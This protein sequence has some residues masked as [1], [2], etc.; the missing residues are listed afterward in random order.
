MKSGFKHTIHWIKCQSKISTKILNRYL[1]YLIYISFQGINTLS[2]LLFEDITHRKRDK[3]YFLLKVEIKD[4]NVMIDGQ[5]IFDQ[6]V[7][8]DLSTFDNVQKVA[9]A[10]GDDY[11]TGCL[12]E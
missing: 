1:D 5:N 12:L 8:D 7:K 11:T 4:Y 10:Q 2:V 3:V 6:P 9:T